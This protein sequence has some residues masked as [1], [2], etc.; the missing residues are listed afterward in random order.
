MPVQRQIILNKP[1]KDN[2]LVVLNL[3]SKSRKFNCS[4]NQSRMLIF[5]CTVSVVRNTRLLRQLKYIGAVLSI[6]PNMP[7][8]LL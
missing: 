6:H 1:P 4:R 2:G 3:Q 8:A 5:I 7:H